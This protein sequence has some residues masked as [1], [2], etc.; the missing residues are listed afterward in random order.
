[1]EL[2]KPAPIRRLPLIIDFADAEALA[3]ERND[4]FYLVAFQIQYWLGQL[5]A[6][7][8][9]QYAEHKDPRDRSLQSGEAFRTLTEIF[10]SPTLDTRPAPVSQHLTTLNS[11]PPNRP[12]SLD[13]P[14]APVSQHLTTLNSQP[15]NPSSLL[16][17]L[18]RFSVEDNSPRNTL[19][20]ALARLS[21]EHHCTG[22][23]FGPKTMRQIS[24]ES[25]T[26][27]RE[28]EKGLA[29]DVRLSSLDSLCERTLVRLCQWL[30]SEIHL[31]THRHWHESPAAFDPDPE[32]RYLAALGNTQRH[33]ANLDLHAQTCWVH[34]MAHA[35]Q[36]F[37]NSPKWAALGKAMSDNSDRSWL[38]PEVDTLVIGLWPVVTAFNWTYRD[39]LNVIRALLKRPETYPC[40]PEHEFPPYCRNVL[41]L[42]K[43]RRGRSAKNGHPLGFDI[44][45]H[46]C[47]PNPRQSLNT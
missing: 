37:K 4:P 21:I 27:G 14:G 17:C 36:Q 38:Y 2:H 10:K 28:P 35:A 24:R 34:H 31:R 6:S 32:T 40:T 1:M 3:T 16:G 26:E 12:S 29:L 45:Q 42:K 7:A 23:Y 44:A 11:Q 20:H 19:R 41:G 9:A 25:R 22:D 33:L 46:L 18:Y 30:D 47:H 15:P 5:L 8:T 13:A 43:A 39:L